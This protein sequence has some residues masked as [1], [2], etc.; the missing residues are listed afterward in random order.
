M[1]RFPLFILIFFWFHAAQATHIIGGELYYDCLGNNQYR[2]TLKVYRDCYNGQAPFDDPAALSIWNGNINSLYS[3]ISI[4]FPGSANV[5]FISGNPCFQAP[6]NVCVEEAVYTKI[7]TLPASTSSYIIAYQR[8]CRNNTIINLANPG[9]TGATYTETIPPSSV[10]T[11]NSSP[12]FNNFPPIA[13]C[14]GETLV[15]DHS[16][17]DPDGDSLVYEL[18]STYDGASPTDPQPSVTS[19][20]P[21]DYITFTGGYSAG[22]PIASAPPIT[23]DPQ[24]GEL[25]VKPTQLG[26]YVVGVCVKEYRNGMLIG[27]HRRD[28]Q[29]NV[30]ICQTNVVADIELP[31]YF[32]PGPGGVYY[33]CN[34]LTVPFDNLSINGWYY[35]WNFGDPATNADTSSLVTPS[36]TYTDSGTYTIQMIANPGYFCADTDYIRLFVKEGVN[37]DFTV[38]PGQCI[39]GN[40]FNFN[41]TGQYDTGT[42]FSWTFDNGA[43][44]P[45]STAVNPSGISYAAPGIYT[46]HVDAEDQG[47]T[48]SATH[49]VIVYGHPSVDFSVPQIGCVPYTATFSMTIDSA[50]NDLHYLWSFGDG[51]SSSASSPV[52]VYYNEGIYDVSLVAYATTGCKD[53]IT[54]I[55]PDEITVYPV[56]HAQFSVTPLEQSIFNPEFWFF[57]ESSLN[58]SCFLY[59]DN[60]DSTDQCTTYYE[61][62]DT[63]HY[64]VTQIVYNSFGCPDTFI[65]PIVVKPEFTFYIPNTFTPDGDNLN[66]GFRGKGIGVLD[67]EFRIY[68]RWG[69][70][71]FYT[72][73]QFASWNGQY[74]NTGDK[75]P[76]GIYVYAFDVR[77]VFGELHRYRGKVLLIR[78]TEAP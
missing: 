78:P 57:D 49:Q 22:Y 40:S 34:G 51:H 35:A 37:I 3:T 33:S 23:I 66:D 39:D 59:F 7:I 32:T 26:Q 29:F 28:F 8:C 6:P 44:P 64:N 27:T 58:I 16:A 25:V 21:F 14:M 55:R 70:V 73:D 41:I 15:F 31:S 12:R 60:G 4:N 62:T 45:T 36:Y 20:P 67:F 17:T 48:D 63:G 75:V 13:L 46:V 72:D 52:H 54:I 10:V 11:C 5:P 24:T 1:K 65:V 50:Y 2:I 19:A 30:T 42:N 74:N 77:D 56:P 38:P 71:I 61:Y 9:G 68:D 69:G 18:C 53:T 47:C 76:D 43:S